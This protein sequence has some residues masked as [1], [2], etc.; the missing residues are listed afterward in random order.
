MLRKQTFRW[1]G[2]D[3]VMLPLTI[4]M[5]ILWIVLKLA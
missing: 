1:T 5:A 2:V 3:K 4:G